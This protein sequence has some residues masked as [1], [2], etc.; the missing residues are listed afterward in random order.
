MQP[1]TFVG[2]GRR[3]AYAA[4]RDILGMIDGEAPGGLQAMS[5]G[6]GVAA[7]AT[8]LVLAG[9]FVEEGVATALL[10]DVV[11]CDTTPVADG[12]V[13]DAYVAHGMSLDAGYETGIT[14]IGIADID[15][16]DADILDR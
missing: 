3:E 8:A 9:R 5:R 2:C 1:R 10:C 14:A 7:Y 15:M 16:A 6:L 11:E 12:E 4:E 13:A